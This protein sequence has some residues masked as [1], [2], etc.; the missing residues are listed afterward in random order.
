MFFLP[1][2]NSQELTANSQFNY[3][4]A[5]LC[6]LCLKPIIDVSSFRKH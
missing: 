2:A 5:C 4:L 3:S 1:T 6:R